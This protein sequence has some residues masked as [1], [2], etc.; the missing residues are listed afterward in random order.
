MCQPKKKIKLSVPA[1]T[2]A[3]SADFVGAIGMGRVT[4]CSTL[5]V[6]VRP[7]DF[8]RFIF[9]IPDLDLDLE[10]VCDCFRRPEEVEV[11][12]VGHFS[13]NATSVCCGVRKIVSYLIG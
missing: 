10:R 2:L 6:C 12:P 5:V 7:R 4:T 1:L 11:N 9:G 8:S 13:I 3:D